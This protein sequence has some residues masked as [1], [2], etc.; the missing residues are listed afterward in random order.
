[1]SAQSVTGARKT[2]RQFALAMVAC[3]AVAGG[4]AVVAAQD[5]APAGQQPSVAGDEWPAPTKS[6]APTN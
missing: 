6:P 5:S 3:L 1:M 2:V 4:A